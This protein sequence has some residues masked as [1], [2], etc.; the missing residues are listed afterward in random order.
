VLDPEALLPGSHK[1]GDGRWLVSTQLSAHSAVAPTPNVMVSV[2][3]RLPSG[4][5]ETSALRNTR[6]IRITCRTAGAASSGGIVVR[7]PRACRWRDQGVA[8]ALVR[9]EGLIGRGRCG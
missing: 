9:A 2:D 5:G 6:R 4:G 1:P 3:C 7:K 8:H